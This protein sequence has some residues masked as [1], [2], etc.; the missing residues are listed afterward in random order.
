MLIDCLWIV[1]FDLQH[2]RFVS[3]PHFF[4]AGMGVDMQKEYP[5]LAKD[6]ESGQLDSSVIPLP[7]L[8]SGGCEGADETFGRAALLAGHSVVHLLCK[9]NEKAGYVS[10]NVAQD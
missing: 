6:L 4:F 5:N 7:M 10:G 9:E 1:L 8:L 2:L 3:Q